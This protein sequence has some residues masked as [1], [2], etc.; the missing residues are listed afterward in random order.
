MVIAKEI[1]PG[2]SGK[3]P[4][5]PVGFYALFFLSLPVLVDF[6]KF[7]L[8]LQGSRVVH[9]TPDAF[10]LIARASAVAFPSEAAIDVWMTA[11][12][13]RSE[14][15]HATSPNVLIRGVR[16]YARSRCCSQYG[17]FDT[18]VLV[19]CRQFGLS[20]SSHA[21]CRCGSLGRSGFG[22]AGL[23]SGA[24]CCGGLRGATNWIGGSGPRAGY[25]PN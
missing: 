19:H 15:L 13:G 17:Q 2:S 10:A 16:M 18:A 9:L 12:A 5:L 22:S 24:L 7:S 25:G 11:V 8:S 4:M 1:I 23:N 3:N 6:P 21:H 20:P 14:D